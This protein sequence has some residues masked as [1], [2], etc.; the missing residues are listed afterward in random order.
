MRICHATLQGELLEPCYCQW[1][2]LV[3]R[4]RLILVV[5]AAFGWYLAYH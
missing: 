2:Q 4:P 5:V 1:R 3:I